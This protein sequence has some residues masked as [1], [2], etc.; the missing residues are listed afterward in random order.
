MC[1]EGMY[2]VDMQGGYGIRV[3]MLRGYVC[4]Y[5]LVT[6]LCFLPQARETLKVI[7]ER[8]KKQREELIGQ[9]QR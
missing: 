9:I 4:R 6:M 5:V 1:R 2:P 7:M 8:Q 3:G